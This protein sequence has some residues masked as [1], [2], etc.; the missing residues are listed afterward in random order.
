M[1][2]KAKYI[3]DYKFEYDRINPIFINQNIVV[4]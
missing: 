2:K 4:K 1:E 3:I